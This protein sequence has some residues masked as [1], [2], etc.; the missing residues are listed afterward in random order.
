MTGR[1]RMGEAMRAGGAFVVLALVLTRMVVSFDP[2][3]YWQG[4]PTVTETIITGVTPAWSVA[5]DVLTMLVAAAVLIGEALAEQRVASLLVILF[6]GGCAGVIVHAALVQGDQVGNIWLG[7]NWAAAWAGAIALWHAGRDGRLHRLATAV[8][9]AVVV[10]L[11]ARGALQVFI[12]HDET[13]RS[14]EI[15]RQ[16]FLEERGWR[17]GSPSHLAYERRLY[18]NDATG[19]FGLSNVYATV[20]A[21]ALT[22]LLG[23]SVVAVRLAMGKAPRITGGWAGL[24]ALGAVAAA[25]GLWWSNSTGGIGSALVGIACLTLAGIVAPRWRIP[26]VIRG[27]IGPGIVIVVLAAILARGVVGE[28]W[29][30]LSILFRSFYLTTAARVFVE[31]PLGVGP[32][33]FQQAYMVLKPAISTE[34]VASPHSVLLDYTACLGLLGL[35]WAAAIILLGSWAGSTLVTQRGDEEPAAPGVL[36]RWFLLGAIGLPLIVSTWIE[37]PL[38]TPENLLL[39]L[40]GLLG[41]IGLG[42]AVLSLARVSAWYRAA[43][44]TGALAGLA[45]AQLD[46]TPVTPG[47][48]AWLLAMI[49]LAAS[50][51]AA[52]SD[53]RGTPGRMQ[54]PLAL[55]PAVVAV[56]WIV[57]GLVPLTRWEADLRRAGEAVQ[58]VGQVHTELLEIS[59]SPVQR[60]SRGRSFEDLTRMV[61]GLL[62]TR[63]AANAEELTGQM[64]ALTRARA[65]IAA[66]FLASASRVFPTHFPT[67][68][69]ASRMY[70]AQAEAAG[71]LGDG[72]RADREVEAAIGLIRSLTDHGGAPAAAWV[73]LGDLLARQGDARLPE[74]IECW[75]EAAKLDPHG[76]IPATR[77]AHGYRNLGRIEESR[78]WAA[79]ALRIDEDLRLDPLER[80]GKTER[81][82]LE[83][84]AEGG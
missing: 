73:W 84:M 74:S 8:C 30:E 28:R 27:A 68:R 48:S 52:R 40:V 5:M 45:H 23:M 19:W 50:T 17:E 72:E 55:A 7:A 12:E 31:H 75:L 46:V 49:A 33:G 2:M 26:A 20:T 82:E 39:R 44:A 58:V 3:P 77:L 13:V 59:A 83:A 36:D 61:A 21:V 4:D 81:Q 25:A 6:A 53:A 18:Q 43:L 67:A 76:L 78:L 35:C 70:L 57:I 38:I 22:A 80:L 32:A 71:V 54:I 47:A 14:Y 65:D 64:A 9:L 11:V 63:S 79:R 66:R 41:G 34:D 62:G 51:M 37:A 16:A 56:I 24:I 29:G 10:V 42:A 69:A 15:G 1:V 60:S